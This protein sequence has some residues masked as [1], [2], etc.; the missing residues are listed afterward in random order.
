MN[1]SSFFS[2]DKLVEFGI[3]LSLARQMVNTMNACMAQTAVPTV[4]LGVPQMPLD[5][6]YATIDNQVAGPLTEMEMSQLIA[7]QKITEETMVWKQGTQGWRQ[8]KQVPEIY[9]W[10]LINK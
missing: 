3:G 8:A 6:F 4:K 2:I 1:E 10:L 7:K 5:Q 9:K